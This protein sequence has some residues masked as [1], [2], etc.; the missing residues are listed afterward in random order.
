MSNHES[1]K[2]FK[3]KEII[4]K[5]SKKKKLQ[6]SKSKCP[7]NKQL[8]FCYFIKK[9]SITNDRTDASLNSQTIDA[10]NKKRKQLHKKKYKS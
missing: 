3:N 6:C 7:S 5:V 9:S 8:K 10:N 2:S 4:S 1:Q